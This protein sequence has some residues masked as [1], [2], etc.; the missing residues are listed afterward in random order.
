MKLKLLTAKILTVSLLLSLLSSCQPYDE[1]QS[2][3]GEDSAVMSSGE[4]SQDGSSYEESNEYYSSEIDEPTSEDESQNSTVSD[5][6][7]EQSPPADSSEDASSPDY[8]SDEPSEEPSV[9]IDVTDYGNGNM[10][11]ISEVMGNN[12]CLWDYKYED[13]IELYKNK[14][15]CSRCKH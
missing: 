4:L 15:T 9:F 1:G 3:L 10:L 7:S 6:P 13:W 14:K 11:I 2:S 8:S 12:D 5:D